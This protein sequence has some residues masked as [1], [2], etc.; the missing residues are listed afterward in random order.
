M[1]TT[2][3]NDQS[4]TPLLKDLKGL[5]GFV[6][7]HWAVPKAKVR[8]A[9]DEKAGEVGLIDVLAW[10]SAVEYA[11]KRQKAV[12][13][14]SELLT[15]RVIEMNSTY[16]P[17]KMTVTWPRWMQDELDRLDVDLDY[18]ITIG[19]V[20]KISESRCRLN[21]V[22]LVAQRALREV[23]TDLLKMAIRERVRLLP[24]WE[25]YD[26]EPG[27]SAHDNEIVAF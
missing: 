3:A 15:K 7:V 23:F 8:Q 5:K 25:H 19:I 16:G 20:P 4:N 21:L 11:Y 22:V 26:L 13:K 6:D 10:R 1:A 24:E 12:L 17:P 27:V 18:D 14:E 2:N 9:L